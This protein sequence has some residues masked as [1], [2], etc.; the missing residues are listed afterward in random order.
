M[1]PLRVAFEQGHHSQVRKASQAVLADPAST[2][3]DKAE[4][5]DLIERTKADPGALLSAG[6]M[7]LI[8]VC[9]SAALAALG[10][11]P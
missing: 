5:R 9:I 11:L 2:E 3:A 4:A 7:A 1:K 8:F 10:K 6:V